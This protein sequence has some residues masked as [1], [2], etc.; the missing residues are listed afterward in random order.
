MANTL[1]AYDPIFY[2]QEGLI[3]LEKALGMAGRVHRGY[4]KNP[5][6]KGSTITISGPSTFTAQD[7]PSVA[8]DLAPTSVSITLDQWKEVKFALSDKELSFTKE[9]IITDHIRP[10]AYALADK[11]DQVLCALYKEIPWCAD[12]S[13]PAAVSDV[14]NAQRILFDN[15]VPMDDE[16]KLHFMVSG[17]IRS[18]LLNLPA[19]SQNQGAG[20]AGVMTQMRGQIGQRFGFNFF[21]NQNTPSHTSGVAADYTGA[22]NNGAGYAAGVKTMAVDGVTNA[23]TFKTGDPFVI[24]G[25]TQQYVLTADATADGSGQLSAI[26]FEPGLESAVVDNQVVTF[27][28]GGSAKPQCLAF[29][30]HF[31]ALACAPLSELGNQLGAKIATIT[32]PISGLSIRS[33]LFYDGDNSKV[34][35]ALDLLFGVKVLNRNLAL[36]Y[37]D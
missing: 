11:V 15:R 37:R 31:A 27:N 23:G 24:T 19:F 6:E 25:H 30:S 2:A 12:W 32:D 16:S 4:D 1:A 3:Q 7:A 14:T 18:E 22:V 13:G 29:H 36:R 9:K 35:V 8:Q 33:R 28:L 10:A 34:K 5:Q 26:S 20:D 17:L 21:A